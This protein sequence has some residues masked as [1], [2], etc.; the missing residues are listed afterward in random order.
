MFVRDSK[1]VTAVNSPPSLPLAWKFYQS[2]HKILWTF[3]FSVLM[4]RKGTQNFLVLAQSYVFFCVGSLVCNTRKLSCYG[5]MLP[6]V[7][8][9]G[10][11]LACE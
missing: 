11:A 2:N 4:T 1:E 10:Y 9:S 7:H 5:F 3:T 8:N 6:L